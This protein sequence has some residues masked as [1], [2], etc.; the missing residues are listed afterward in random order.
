MS[1]SGNRKKLVRNGKSSKSLDPQAFEQIHAEEMMRSSIDTSSSIADLSEIKE[2]VEDDLPPPSKFCSSAR[3]DMGSVTSITP[4]FES[5]ENSPCS[6]EVALSVE[7]KFDEDSASA[8]DLD[9]IRIDE[10]NASPLLS[11]QRSSFRR[12]MNF[13]AGLQNEVERRHQKQLRLVLSPELSSFE[14]TL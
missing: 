2:V 7:P 6:F 5:F 13:A 12:K 1:K 4:A 11:T 9:T 8:L 3:Q 10:Y 14:T